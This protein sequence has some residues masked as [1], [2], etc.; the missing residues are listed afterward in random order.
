MRNGSIKRTAFAFNERF[1]FRLIRTVRP[2][3]VLC[4]PD[5]YRTMK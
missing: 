2:N 3:R 4:T 1:P 5:P